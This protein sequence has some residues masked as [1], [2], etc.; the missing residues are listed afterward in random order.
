[1]SNLAN[2]STQNRSTITE[3]IDQLRD[4]RETAAQKLW[5]HFLEK[6]TDLVR[7]RLRHSPKRLSDEEDVV[8]D[9]CEACFR[10]LK[11]GRYS[12]IRSREN[13]WSLLAVVAERKAIDQ[14]RRNTKGVDGLRAPATFSIVSDS[15]SILDGVEQWPCTEPTPEFAAIFI[16]NLRDRLSLLNEMHSE[17]AVLKMQGFSNREISQKIGRSVPSVERYLKKI[18]AE[19]SNESEHAD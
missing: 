16:E 5:D 13:L 10:A 1:M 9:A 6:L 15:S 11:E 19:W 17:V 7:K 14:I 3:W 8:L 18:R 2:D 4:G 12:D